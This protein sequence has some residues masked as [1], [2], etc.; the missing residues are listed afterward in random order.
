MIREGIDSKTL[1][2]F[3]YRNAMKDF[4]QLLHS[5]L[6]IEQNLNTFG[7]LS[8]NGSLQSDTNK[9]I[10][11]KW[12]QVKN[13]LTNTWLI[14]T[15]LMDASDVVSNQIDRLKQLQYFSD[16]TTIN[17]QKRKVKCNESYFTPFLSVSHTGCK[18]YDLL[19]G[20]DVDES[21]IQG[22]NNGVTFIFM[23]GSKIS[24]MGY[25]NNQ[26][27]NIPGFQNTFEASSG[28]EGIRMIIHH[29]KTS[30]WPEHEGIDVSPGF[31]TIIGID[32]K[33]N[34]RLKP[35]YSDCT[36]HNNEIEKLLHSITSRLGYSP[37]RK[38]GLEESSYTTLEC[39]SSCLQRQIWENCDCLLLG[40]YLP[41]FNSSFLCGHMAKATNILYNPEAYAKEHC[42]D[43][44]NMTDLECTNFLSKLFS[45]LS[46][47]QRVLTRTN[48]E[49]IGSNCDCPTPCRSMEYSLTIGTSSWPSPGP[50]LDAAYTSIVRG[51]VIPDFRRKQTPLLNRTIH[52]F[53]NESNKNEIIANFARVTVYIRSL[54]VERSEQVAAYT[55]LDLISDIGKTICRFVPVTDLIGS[56]KTPTCQ[57]EFI[58]TRQHRCGRG[59]FSTFPRE[60]VPM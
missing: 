52:Y 56:G 37:S 8:E 5:L 20:S 60:W 10:L 2:E 54:K 16:E 1:R 59:M 55:I 6:K 47:V 50:E 51:I 14:T 35:P 57:N 4:Y 7:Q 45:D 27:W 18:T 31:S 11:N 48:S 41:F 29:P 43:L 19:E 25:D 53:E 58:T 9:T 12:F 33:E 46:C 15:L 38:D 17:C 21:R 13:D 32:A 36:E 23:T 24:A 44:Q 39:R 3:S 26:T 49:I 40:E 34:I 42:F 28:S 30:L 22:V